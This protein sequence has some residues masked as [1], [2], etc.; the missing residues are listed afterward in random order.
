VLLLVNYRP[1]YRHRWGAKTCYTEFRIDPLDRDSVETIVRDLL[2]ADPDVDALKDL[3]V[4]TTE[5]NPFFLEEC[6]RALVETRALV[7]RPGAYRLGAPVRS[8][9]VPATV[10][11]VLAARIDRLPTEEKALLQSAAV[12]GKTVSVAA[13]QMLAPADVVHR[14]LA[15]LQAAEFLYETRAAPD[16]EYT[17]KHALTHEV[18][19]GSLLHDTRRDLHARLVAA[20]EGAGGDRSREQVER[21]AHHAFHGEVWDKAVTYL[22]EAG[23]NAFA[24]A[25]HREAA[26]RLTQALAALERLPGTRATSEQ[27]IDLRLALR[28]ALLP[29][30]EVETVLRCLREAEALA[31]S[32]EDQRRAGWISAYLSACFWSIGDYA[33]G[34]DAARQAHRA[35]VA[36]GD[37]ALQV[38]ASTAHTWPYHSL[39]QYRAGIASAVEAIDL[40]A[41]SPGLERLDIP[42]RPAVLARTWL[43]SCLAEIGEFARAAPLA[44]EAV[45]LAEASG[46]PWSLVDACLGTGILHLRRGEIAAATGILS[47]GLDVSRRFH[48]DVWFPPLASSL[49]HTL[50]VSGNLTEALALLERAALQAATTGLR[51]YHSLSVLWLAEAYR[52]AA[53]G[54]DA[55]RRALEALALCDRYHEAGNRAYT[56]RVLG[57]LAA[58]DGDGETAEQ[59]FR[60][61]LRVGTELEMRP[62]AAHC[63]LDLGQLASR[64]GRWPEAREAL[65][66]A[67]ELLDELEMKAWA[68]R[69]RGALQA[70]PPSS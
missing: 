9:R 48:I 15:E 54:A 13:L 16:Q 67:V 21:L 62:L 42:S 51:F 68:E 2:G 45:R 23:A 38:Y 69:A 24:Q 1:E 27:A 59:W 30:G 6:L 44:Q 52:L 70:L 5:G 64:S 50:A 8:I 43:V 28:N 19:Y 35:A 37:V 58:E 10:Q 11:A 53:R 57:A 25:A 12:I 20:M 4:G 40:L 22:R 3:L 18:A 66:T 46:E 14:T 41:A 47:R 60:E 17:F 55:R 56:L 26:E 63:H 31:R 34:L 36:L 49:G 29:V 33:A 32:L 39:G 65:T 7:G 61:S